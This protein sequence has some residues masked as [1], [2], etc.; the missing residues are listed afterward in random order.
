M[1]TDN[2]GNTTP[3][4]TS[5]STSPAWDP[6]SR[7][8][9]GIDL[10]ETPRPISLHQYSST[11]ENIASTSA[12][13]VTYNH[14]LLKDVLVDKPMLARLNGGK[15]KDKE[16]SIIVVHTNRQLSICQDK[17]RTSYSIKPEWVTPTALKATH[18]NGLLI[19]IKGEHCGKYVRCLQHRHENGQTYM[20]VSEV[21]VANDHVDTLT[22][23]PM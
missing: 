3:M 14:V 6:T 10:S 18:D 8:L 1:P 17:Y 15:Y 7:T 23:R 22:G 2:V 5:H 12:V 16:H 11:P 21:T 9:L 4:P 19:V 13:S 20:I